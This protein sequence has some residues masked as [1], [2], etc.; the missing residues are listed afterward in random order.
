MLLELLG[1]SRE[2]IIADFLES[3]ATFPKMPLS[4]RQLEPIFSLID[5]S[6]GIEGFLLDALGL[7]VT[8]LEA[9]RGDLLEPAGY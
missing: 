6:G 3:N 1:V 7:D 4:E 8:D 2:L 9:I 5:E